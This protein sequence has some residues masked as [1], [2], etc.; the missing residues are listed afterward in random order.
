MVVQCCVCGKV[1]S[2]ERWV[3][4]GKGALL[5]GAVSHGYC[6]S[7]AHRAFAEI[8]RTAEQRAAKSPPQAAL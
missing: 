1:R 7:C 6:P 2:G 3:R 4:M 5:T 8:R